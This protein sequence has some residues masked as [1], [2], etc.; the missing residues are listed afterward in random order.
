M[1]P[2]E[3]MACGVPVVAYPCGR[4]LKKL[5]VQGTTGPA[6]DPDKYPRLEALRHAMPWSDRTR[7]AAWERPGAKLCR[8]GFFRCARSRGIGSRFYR[9]LPGRI[10]RGF[11]HAHAQ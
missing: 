10:G 9:K 7:L 11:P 8:V 3:A 1:T 6:V 4:V 2:I 5:C